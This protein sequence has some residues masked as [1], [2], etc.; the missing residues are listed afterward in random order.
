MH[1]LEDSI[2]VRQTHMP[3]ED[4][5]G[6]PSQMTPEAMGKLEEILRMDWTVQEAIV[7][8]DVSQDSYYYHY[9]TYPHFRKRMDKARD[10]AKIAARRTVVSDIEAGDSRL[11]MEFLRRRDR[12]HT[13][14][15]ADSSTNY[16][17]ILLWVTDEAR[18][19]LVQKSIECHS[20]AEKKPLPLEQSSKQ[21][22]E[23]WSDTAS[24]W[25]KTT[26]SNGFMNG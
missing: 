9:W 6:R 4:W 24:T 14:I 23:V 3:N 11:A 18:E 26:K 1:H 22:E 7:Y 5:I 8:A 12:R 20:I 21:P 15:E 2:L 10:Y 16:I 19:F 17:N 25:K 13:Q